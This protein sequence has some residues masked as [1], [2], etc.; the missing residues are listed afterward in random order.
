[1][2]NWSNIIIYSIPKKP[3]N[4]YAKIIE[5]SR[6]KILERDLDLTLVNI[7]VD[8]RNLKQTTIHGRYTL[9][10]YWEYSAEVFKVFVDSKYTYDG[11]NRSIL[12]KILPQFDFSIKLVQFTDMIISTADWKGGLK[13]GGGLP[14]CFKKLAI[15]HRKYT[16][17]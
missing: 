15:R 12:Y 1:M 10:K 17:Y 2:D 6:T 13:Q 7:K 4:W 11:N 14:L 9:E 3:T 16:T 8:L 5:A